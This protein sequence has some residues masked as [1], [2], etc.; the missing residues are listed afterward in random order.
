MQRV[1]EWFGRVLSRGLLLAA[2]V[3]RV[4][5][6]EAD[7]RVEGLHISALI[8]QRQAERQ[9]LLLLFLFVRLLYSFLLQAENLA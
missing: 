6:D 4:D 5:Y 8:S 7:V 3:W 9:L 1:M 2:A